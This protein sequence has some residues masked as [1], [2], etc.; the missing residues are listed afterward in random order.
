M[1]AERL[2]IFLD[3]LNEEDEDEVEVV[4][5]LSRIR[6]L[7]RRSSRASWF[8]MTSCAATAWLLGCLAAGLLLLL[9]LLLVL[10]LVLVLL[11]P[12]PPPLLLLLSSVNE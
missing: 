5:S 2:G 11:L 4:V 9:L 8:W 3:R 12:P 6:K 7:S 1:A 10:V